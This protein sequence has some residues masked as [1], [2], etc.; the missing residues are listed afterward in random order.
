[1]RI[2]PLQD[3]ED[4]LKSSSISNE[5]KAKI[6]KEIDDVKAQEEAYIA[7]EKELEVGG[8]R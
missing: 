4:K 1:M 5:E 8:K 3:L 6:Q 7:K 2:Y